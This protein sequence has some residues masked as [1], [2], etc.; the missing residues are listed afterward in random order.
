MLISV[1]SSLNVYVV[2]IELKN[3]D[4]ATPMEVARMLGYQEMVDLLETK[5][6][7]VSRNP[8]IF[9]TKSAT[10]DSSSVPKSRTSSPG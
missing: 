9:T 8:L 7:T 1:Y 2:N 3:N 4:G 6:Q 10:L 5:E